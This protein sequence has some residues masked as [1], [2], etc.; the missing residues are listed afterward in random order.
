MKKLRVGIVGCGGISNGKHMPSLKKVEE[1][2]MVAFCDLIEERA[3]KAMKQYGTPDAYYTTNYMDIANDPNIDVVHVLT[4]N[5]EHSFISIAMLEHGKHVMSEKPM[6]INAAEAKKMLDAAAKSG[7]KLT[8][9][10]QNRQRPEVQQMREVVKSG[11]LGEIYFAK[12]CALR[13]RGIPTW[14]VFMNEYEQGGGPII[15]IATHSLDLTLWAMDNYEPQMV[16][17]STFQ[18]LG[19]QPG[20]ANPW[21]NFDHTKFTVEDAGFGFVKMKNGATIIIESSWALNLLDTGAE[22]VLCGTKGGAKILNCCLEVNGEKFGSLYNEKFV[23]PEDAD[24][25]TGLTVDASENE[26]RQWIRSIINDTDPCVLPKQA[27]VVSQ[28]LDAI[29]TS[30]K[31]NK[32]VFFD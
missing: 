20:L 24:F 5:R 30:A 28:I 19:N 21:G 26:A 6:A 7:K 23:K 9:G 16:V 22:S 14:G 18:K 29:Y 8:V 27:F 15:D 10:Y 25:Y 2:E 31:T 17:G 32:P 11:A 4:P 13:R 1:C 12:A 3:V